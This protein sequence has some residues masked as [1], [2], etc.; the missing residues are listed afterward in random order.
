MY[1]LMLLIITGALNIILRPMFLVVD[2]VLAMLV[3]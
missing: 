3:R 2:L 1:I